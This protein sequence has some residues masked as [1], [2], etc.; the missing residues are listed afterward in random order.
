M[1]H[2]SIVNRNSV[3]GVAKVRPVEAKRDFADGSDDEDDS[4]E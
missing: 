3:G 1:S 2:G 4:H